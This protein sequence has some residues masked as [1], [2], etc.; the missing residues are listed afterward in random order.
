MKKIPKSISIVISPVVLYIEDLEEI[1]EI[2]KD[3]FEDYKIIAKSK[4][5]ENDFEFN[6]VQEFTENF[7]KRNI[8]KLNNLSFKAYNLSIDV[9]FKNDIAIIYS[10]DNEAKSTGI[11]NKLKNIANQRPLFYKVLNNIFLFY[12]FF[13]VVLL[14]DKLLPEMNFII[15]IISLLLVL[16]GFWMYNLLTKNYSIIYLKRRNLQK[17]FL[18]RNK[19]AIELIGTVVAIIGIIFTVISLS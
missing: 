13:F 16:W 19:I 14:L 7:N 17:G 4:K 3:N 1:E 10:S 6:S 12:I 15:I 18:E 11:T 2:Y 9:D 5:L 8:I